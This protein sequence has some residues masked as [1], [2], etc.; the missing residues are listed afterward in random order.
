MSSTPLDCQHQQITPLDN[1]NQ[2]SKLQPH[3]SA[4]IKCLFSL[5][6]LSVIKLWEGFR[7]WEIMLAS[8]CATKHLRLA[9]PSRWHIAFGSY[10]IFIVKCTTKPNGSNRSKQS[11]RLIFRAV[12][13]Y[14]VESWKGDC[15]HKNIK[16]GPLSLQLDLLASEGIKGP[17]LAI[18]W[19]MQLLPLE[20]FSVRQHGKMTQQSK[21]VSQ[22]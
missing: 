7:V 16:I 19:I 5:I 1:F 12:R 6:R 8:T 21:M 22:H 10:L 14:L 20:S 2:L 4:M 15:Y 17:S 9:G 13:I 18:C 3:A 11:R